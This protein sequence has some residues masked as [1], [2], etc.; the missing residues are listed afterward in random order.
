MLVAAADH[1]PSLAQNQMAIGL[2][3]A[4]SVDFSFPEA[5]NDFTANGVT[6][7][8]EFWRSDQF[9]QSCNCWQVIDKTFHPSYP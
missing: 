3:R 9:M 5:P 2:Q 6:T 4:Q 8:G 1:A 7:G